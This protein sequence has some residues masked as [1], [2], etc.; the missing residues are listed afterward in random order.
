MRTSHNVHNAIGIQQH[1]CI[2]QPATER[3]RGNPQDSRRFHRVLLVADLQYLDL[4]P[5]PYLQ[6]FT[7]RPRL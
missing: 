1:A 7:R 5:L 3:H 2:P 4:R 6:S